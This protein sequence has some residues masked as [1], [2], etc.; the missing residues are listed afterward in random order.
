MKLPAVLDRALHIV[1]RAIESV[2]LVLLLCLTALGVSGLVADIA[3]SLG[4]H[5]YLDL[6]ALL[7]D[8]D[9][10]LAI[11]ILVELISIVVAYLQ[12]QRVFRRVIEAAFVAVTRKIIAFEPNETALPKGI[13]LALL[14]LS[15]SVS[16]YIFH[17][18]HR[19]RRRSVKASRADPGER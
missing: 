6:S 5:P 2:L 18:G 16:W 14:L 13:V 10:V 3:G 12:S 9:H 15:L 17:A 8:I 7:H 11:F 1:M 4:H 19:F